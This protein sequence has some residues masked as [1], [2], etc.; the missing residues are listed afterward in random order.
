MTRL[1]LR[2]QIVGVALCC[3]PV[4]CLSRF[5]W[6]HDS[7]E[8]VTL[9]S[10]SRVTR[11]DQDEVVGKEKTY[12][13][14]ALPGGALFCPVVMSATDK[15]A[16]VARVYHVGSRR[17]IQVLEQR[18]GRWEFVGRNGSAISGLDG[19]FLAG[20]QRGWDGR[21]WVLAAY[22]EPSNPSLGERHILY[23]LEN[24]AWKVMG[25]P[26][27]QRTH[28]LLSDDGLHLL[29]TQ[30][31][32]PFRDL[33]CHFVGLDGDRWVPLAAETHL[34][35]TDKQIVWRKDDAWLFRQRR[36]GLQ[37]TLVAYWLKGPRKADIT[38]PIRVG[39]WD[40]EVFLL[41]F[42][43]SGDR[44]VAVFGRL[45]DPNNHTGQ[46]LRLIRLLPDRAIETGDLPFPPIPGQTPSLFDW[47]PRGVLFAVTMR[48]VRTIVVHRFE[49]RRW[50]ECGEVSQP[51]YQIF[52]PHLF[53]RDDGQPIVVWRD[54][55]PHIPVAPARGS[56]EP[57]GSPRAPFPA[58]NQRESRK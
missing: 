47:S 46:F 28:L 1:S 2:L 17:E 14:L 7:G 49:N 58:T 21:S 53:F 6:A 30:P 12:F 33:A 48:N 52:D 43:V 38:G 39:S 50:I 45:R 27:G 18:E 26:Q 24:G 20:A 56:P 23:G 32:H 36:D 13:N 25:P 15:G 10:L 55:L 4:L 37:L 57:R 34:S 19:N 54:F 5:T 9:E 41:D 22:T 3:A 35:E 44:T 29:G 51:R 11:P 16:M 42:A 8:G 40:N 31:V